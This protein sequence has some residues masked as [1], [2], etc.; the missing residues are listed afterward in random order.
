M[1]RQAQDNPQVTY[2]ILLAMIVAGGF[3]AW[4]WKN[5]TEAQ[6]KTALG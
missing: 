3:A 4:G 1:A 2:W 6:K 5:M